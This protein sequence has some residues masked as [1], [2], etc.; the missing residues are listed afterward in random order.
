LAL[1]LLY[2]LAFPQ[3]YAASGRGAAALS[4]IWLF[5]LGWAGGPTAGLLW[6]TANIPLH[7]GLYDRVGLSPNEQ[8][9]HI[10]SPGFI[11]GVLTGWAA[12]QIRQLVEAYRFK[13]RALRFLA[14]LGSLTAKA[15]SEEELLHMVP[16]LATE[17]GSYCCSILWRAHPD[18]RLEPVAW[19][20]PDDCL[21]V[22]EGHFE[23]VR[24]DRVL[25]RAAL[26]G[27]RW[28]QGSLA[29]S[30]AIREGRAVVQPDVVRLPAYPMSELARALR[31]RAVLGAPIWVDG[32]IWGALVVAAAEPRAFADEKSSLLEEAA[33]GVGMALER[34][35]LR[36]TLEELA[37]GDA[38]TGLLNRHGFLERA[39]AVLEAARAEGKSA[40]LLF[41]DLDRFKV[42]NDTLGHAAGDR[43]LAEAAQRLQGVIGGQNPLGRVGG[44]EFAVLL[45]GSSDSGA[46]QVARQ[47]REALRRPFN[48]AQ[49]F[50]TLSA[51]LGM[52]RFPQ[53][54]LE[55]NELLRK[56]DIAMYQA[57]RS[58]DG[59]CFFDASSDRVLHER[60]ELERGLRQALAEGEIQLYYQPV[61]SLPSGA[62]AFFETLA[63]WRI[64]PGVFVP[65][66]EEVGLSWELDCYILS[67]ALAQ[68]AA[69]EHK[70]YPATLSVNLSPRSLT[71]AGLPDFLQA[72]LRRHRLSPRRLILEITEGA[73]VSQ[74]GRA[75]LNRLKSTGVVLALDDFGTGYSSLEQLKTLPVE[76]IK[77]A[78]PFVKDAGHGPKDTAVVRAVLTLAQE[79]GL[80][81]VA[82]GV[83]SET[84]RD[85]LE[86][87]GYRLLQGYL[88]SKPL[89]AEEALSWKPPAPSEH[90]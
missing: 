4:A 34:L 13:E 17:V 60:L 82:E 77:V 46:L 21:Q 56:A 74:G 88:F 24:E 71:E 29:A 57:K 73:V 65:L 19:A 63:R 31:Y 39:S 85:L 14:R 87:I 89:P 2:I 40:I 12:G 51:S 38:L 50:F 37:M 81:A 76:L 67:R 53:D 9:L 16:I 49:Q 43:L 27:L 7:L 83:E 42:V 54:G 79:M 68:L 15:A 32:Q 75:A 23:V 30:R 72:E 1:L 3:L 90:P 61:V 8:L 18:G 25:A 58:G 62:V 80:L 55:L 44:D 69:W 41:L 84:Q 28:D 22:R 45:Y 78:R 59:M 5:L 10:F 6:G 35:A 52:A 66:A 11:T 20:S 48:Q 86:R 26:G 70:G 36:L 64:P 47:V 33:R